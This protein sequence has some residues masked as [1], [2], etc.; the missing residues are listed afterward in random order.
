MGS[1]GAQGIKHWTETEESWVLFLTLPLAAG[2]TLGKL[3]HLCFPSWKMGIMM[4]LSLVKCF[5]LP[6]TLLKL[7]TI[8][9]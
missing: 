6:S 2:V 3:V 8:L 9:K 1:S 7:D 5:D 4:L